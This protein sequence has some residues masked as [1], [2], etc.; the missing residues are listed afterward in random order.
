ML[1]RLTRIL[2]KRTEVGA[3]IVTILLII[4]LTAT[5]NGVWLSN[6]NMYE[7][8]RLTS[9]LG[10]MAFGEALVIT[11]GEIDIS[12]GSVFGIVGILYVSLGPQIGAPLAI[13]LA[14]MVAV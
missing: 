10:I 11:V 2:R 1:Y 9:I 12:I 14:M 7:V 4:G 13:L 6:D 5:S 3:I 8:L